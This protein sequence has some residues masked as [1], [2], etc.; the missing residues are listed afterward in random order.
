MKRYSILFTTLLLTALSSST[1]AAELI[2][3]APAQQQEVGVISVS[4]TNLSSME[5]QL[6][7]KADAAGAKSFRIVSTTGN[8]RMH[9]TAAIYQ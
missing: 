3:N 8:N 2:D 9:A 4:G 6:A 5:S 7:E 1:F